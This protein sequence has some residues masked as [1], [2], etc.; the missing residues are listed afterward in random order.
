M[1]EPF[2]VLISILP[3]SSTNMMRMLPDFMVA[4]TGVSIFPSRW[5]HLLATVTLSMVSPLS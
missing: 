3:G 2:S 5:K 1:I 4:I